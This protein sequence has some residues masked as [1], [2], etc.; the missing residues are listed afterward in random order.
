M[1]GSDRGE[2]EINDKAASFAL[3]GEGRREEM[4]MERAR[5]KEMEKDSETLPGCR[6]SVT[7]DWCV[8]VCVLW[9]LAMVATI[10]GAIKDACCCNVL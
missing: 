2:R 5:E 8:C 7:L 9:A 10:A 3:S 1:S 6:S 4:W